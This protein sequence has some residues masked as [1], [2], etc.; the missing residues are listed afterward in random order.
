VN[1][2]CLWPGMARSGKAPRGGARRGLAWLGTVGRGGARQG[3]F[4]A[5]CPLR[6]QWV[7]RWQ[8]QRWGAARH[9]SAGLGMAGRGSAWPGKAGAVY[10]GL[11]IVQA[12]GFPVATP[13]STARC[14]RAWP[15]RAWHGGD[16][17]GV[18]GRGRARQ[19]KGWQQRIGD[20]NESPLQCGRTVLSTFCLGHGL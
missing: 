11:P 6:K 20:F 14:G 10:S 16:G 13:E 19:G 4:T 15:G 18:A 1:G 5:D 9:G 12:V 8:H 2:F 17:P 7:F 3:L